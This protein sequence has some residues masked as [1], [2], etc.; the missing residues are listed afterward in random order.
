MNIDVITNSCVYLAIAIIFGVLGTISMKL[1]YGLK[2]LKPT[3]YLGVFYTISFSAMTLALKHLDLS[4]V[5]AVWSGVGTILVAAIGIIYFNES[6]SLR[7]IFFLLLIIIGV[8][9]IHLG[10]YVFTI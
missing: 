10:D 9:G 4:V 7:K 5:Y 3:I 6:V 1:S 8:A 2:R